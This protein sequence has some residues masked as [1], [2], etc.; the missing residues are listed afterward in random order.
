MFAMYGS[1]IDRLPF[2][3]F[4]PLI[5][6]QLTTPTTIIYQSEIDQDQHVNRFLSKKN[7]AYFLIHF[8]NKMS[9]TRIGNKL[10][11]SLFLFVFSLEKQS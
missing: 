1:S 9:H 8:F 7:S 6:L 2:F 10:L 4:I 11:Y 3:Y 5:L